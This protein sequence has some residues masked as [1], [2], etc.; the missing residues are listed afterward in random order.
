MSKGWRVYSMSKVLAMQAQSSEFRPQNC[1]PATLAMG[2][3]QK[4]ALGLLASQC[5]PNGKVQLQVQ[6]NLSQKLK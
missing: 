1:R 6:G 2:H 4:D 3:R 5:S